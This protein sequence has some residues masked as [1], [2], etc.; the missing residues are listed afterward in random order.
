M[1]RSYRYHRAESVRILANVEL[2]V[3]SLALSRSEVVDDRIPP[4]VI[5]GFVLR[6]ADSLLPDDHADLAL[7]VESLGEL[8]VRKDIISAG[9][10]GG[11]P[12]GED[13]GMGWLIFLV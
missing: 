10:N 7:I 4:H 3:I 5:H 9:D 11:E 2:L 12:F 8:L 13:D 6:Y 1:E